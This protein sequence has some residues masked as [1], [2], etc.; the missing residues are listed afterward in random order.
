MVVSAKFSDCHSSRFK[1][2]LILVWIWKADRHDINEKKDIQ[3]GKFSGREQVPVGGGNQ[4]TRRKLQIYRKS[5]T[6]FIT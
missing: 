3:W 1:R 5:L 2:D 6:N 4:S